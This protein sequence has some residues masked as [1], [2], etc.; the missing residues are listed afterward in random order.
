ML[1]LPLAEEL[2]ACSSGPLAGPAPLSGLRL[3]LSDRGGVAGAVVVVVEDFVHIVEAICTM[4]GLH[5]QVGLRLR[6]AIPLRNCLGVWA[7]AL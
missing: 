6:L 2:D 4:R 3:E 5:L 1:E 7:A